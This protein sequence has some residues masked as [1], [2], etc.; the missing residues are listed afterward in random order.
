[1]ALWQRKT[2]PVPLTSSL[3]DFRPRTYK[4]KLDEW[5]FRKNRRKKVQPCKE[6]PQKTQSQ[7]VYVPS[8]VSPLPSGLLFLATDESSLVLDTSSPSITD[9]TINESLSPSPSHIYELPSC[10]EHTLPSARQT[11]L[12]CQT[13]PISTGWVTNDLFSRSLNLEEIIGNTSL[14]FFSFRTHAE[15]L[16]LLAKSLVMKEWAVEILLRNWNPGEDCLQYA[17]RFLEDSACCQT[18]LSVNW[19]RWTDEDETLFDLIDVEVPAD[20]RIL[21]ALTKA[22]LKADL[23][24]QHPL[25]N[26]R[27][28]WVD[29]WRLA[30]QQTEWSLATNMVRFLVA[31]LVSLRA[32]LERHRRLVY[33]V[34][35]VIA[36]SL[37][38]KNKRILVSWRGDI[39]IF[40]ETARSQ[41]FEILKDCH[42]WGIALDP[43]WYADLI[44]FN[45]I[46][47]GISCYFTSAS[48]N[49]QAQQ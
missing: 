45:T 22:V 48:T 16:Q 26:V 10:S 38:E 33:C 49:I 39:D 27:P 43:S 34:L 36:E 17:L 42:V 20:P 31:Q 4:L 6:P 7:P 14:M 46:D 3:T 11:A 19:T 15:S 8:K 18:L 41:Y 37:L 12:L 13:S 23:K 21:T 28:A 9:S 2:N 29:T 44:V 35:M 47:H 32:R 40:F 1:M 25:R 5:K 24:F 30:L